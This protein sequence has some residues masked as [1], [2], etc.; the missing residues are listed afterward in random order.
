M[1]KVITAAFETRRDA[2]MAVEH[3]V[4]EYGIDRKAV[5]IAPV[6]AENSAGI[7]TA[8]AD[9]EGGHEKTETEGQPALAGKL[10]V[11]ADV[12]DAVADKVDGAFATYGGKPVQA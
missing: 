8:G 10:R 4:Q 12:D 2:E 1:S 11:S 5:T 3:L 7:R 6:A 9:V